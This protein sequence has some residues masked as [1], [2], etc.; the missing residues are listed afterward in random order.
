MTVTVCPSV[1]IMLARAA[2]HDLPRAGYFYLCHEL[3]VTRSPYAIT[4]CVGDPQ[5]HIQLI[6]IRRSC[7]ADVILNFDIDCCQVAWDGSRVLATPSALRA[8]QTGINIADPECASGEYEWRLAKY[9]MRG[10][11]VAVPGLDVNKVKEKFVRNSCFGY[12]KG[13][14]KRIHLTFTG[15]DWP[16]YR[17]EE[18]TIVQG[19]ALLLVLSTTYFHGFEE[20]E[21]RTN[22]V[23]HIHFH[24]RL[25]QGEARLGL[26]L[27]IGSLGMGNYLLDYGKMERLESCGTWK[28]PTPPAPPPANILRDIAHVRWV[29]TAGTEILPLDKKPRE[30][31]HILNGRP[32]QNFL[33]APVE[34]SSIMDDIHQK[35]LICYDLLRSGRDSNE[36]P[37]VLDAS[38]QYPSYPFP[39]GRGRLTRFLEFPSST[40]VNAIPWASGLGA[41]EWTRGVYESS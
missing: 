26:P 10:F 9:A 35:R 16:E 40:D 17:I 24:R 18:N 12:H 36:C 32:Q 19:L 11:L 21:E 37:N 27:V 7:I 5:R 29:D 25:Q 34:E 39:S 30:V 33:Y 15:K 14:L 22:R 3:L 28:V 38:R 41:E 6:L 23:N 2:T 4:F 13:H 31:F 20:R 8:L 1:L